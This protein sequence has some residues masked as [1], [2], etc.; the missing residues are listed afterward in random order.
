MKDVTRSTIFPSLLLRF[1]PVL[2]G[3]FVL[4]WATDVAAKE[5]TSSMEKS[6]GAAPTMTKGLENEAIAPETP[7]LSQV[8]S[9]NDFSLEENN[10][11]LDQVTSV[12]Q[13]SDVQ[14]TDWA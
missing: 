13:L 8:L 1:S 2:L 9:V 3:L 6:Q 11:S 14:P 7:Q 4:P 10:A 5:V 12:S